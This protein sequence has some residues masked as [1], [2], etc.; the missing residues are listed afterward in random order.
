[1]SVSDWGAKQLASHSKWV[2]SSELTVDWTA[3]GGEGKK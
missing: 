1:M 3:C 2:F